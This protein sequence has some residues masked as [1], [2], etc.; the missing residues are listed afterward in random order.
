MPQ[1]T[2]QTEY[3]TRFPWLIFRTSIGRTLCPFNITNAAL[4]AVTY[5]TIL[6]SAHSEPAG[7]VPKTTFSRTS[8]LGG[9]RDRGIRVQGLGF[10]WGT[11]TKPTFQKL[12][13]CSGMG[14]NF[15][16]KISMHDMSVIEV[17]G[18]GLRIHTYLEG[19]SAHSAPRTR[20]H[21]PKRTQSRDTC[22]SPDHSPRCSRG[23]HNVFPPPLRGLRFRDLHGTPW[24]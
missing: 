10:R 24:C 16:A 14:V 3:I 18:P 8:D 19:S 17:Q 15:K 6:A 2:P 23:Q 5:P 20:S 9:V 13:R 4:S 11:R 22:Q 21:R 7:I 1:P 12:V